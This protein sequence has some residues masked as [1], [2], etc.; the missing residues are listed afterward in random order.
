M[1]V[2]QVILAASK[3]KLTSAINPADE[4]PY[5]MSTNRD[6]LPVQCSIIIKYKKSYWRC[7]IVHKA[8]KL[9]FRVINKRTILSNCTFFDKKNFQ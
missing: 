5:A 1:I 7:N 2:N 4:I 8:I 9:D 6:E 3:I